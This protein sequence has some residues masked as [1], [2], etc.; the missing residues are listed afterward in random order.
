M[1]FMISCVTKMAIRTQNKTSW[2][3]LRS[4]SG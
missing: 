1:L 4:T 3:E 2:D